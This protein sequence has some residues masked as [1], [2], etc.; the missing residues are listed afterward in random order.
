MLQLFSLIESIVVVVVDAAVEWRNILCTLNV[1]EAA[2]AD[3]EQKATT[4][5]HTLCRSHSWMVNDCRE[6]EKEKEKTEPGRHE[7]L[8]E[9][10]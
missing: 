2:D 7:K 6:N 4:A 8:I 5:A 9:Y 3:V 1:C 10:K